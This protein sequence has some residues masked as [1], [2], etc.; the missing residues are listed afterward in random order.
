MAFD[1]GQQTADLAAMGKHGFENR[2]VKN[3]QGS[4]GSE[5]GFLVR[6]EWALPVLGAMYDGDEVLSRVDRVS[7]FETANRMIYTALAHDN[8]GR[9]GGLETSWV[10]ERQQITPS[11]AQLRQVE[12]ELHKLAALVYTTDELMQDVPLLEAEL[13][14]WFM[15]AVAWELVNAIINGTGAGQPQ[16]ILNSPALSTVAPEA[17]QVAGTIVWENLVNMVRRMPAEHRREAVW[18]VSGSAELELMQLGQDFGAGSVPVYLP[19]MVAPNQ[20]YG[21]LFGRPVLLTPQCAE[22]GEVG[23]II[24]CDLGAYKVIDSAPKVTPSIHVRYAEGETAVRFTYRVDGS[25]IYG[26]PMLAAD[27]TTTLSPF[28]TLGERL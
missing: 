3:M 15:Q 13:S 19:S 1:I 4:P 25:G 28:V 17:G 16:G 20:P 8:G 5:G 14:K 27:G 2:A 24:L 12:Y 21:T 18:L 23:D 11:T 7:M 9:I 26:E 10:G 6:P 22:V